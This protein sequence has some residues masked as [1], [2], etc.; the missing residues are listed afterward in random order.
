M[1]TATTSTPRKLLSALAIVTLFLVCLGSYVRVTGAG[2]SCPDWPLC[3]GQVVPKL[4]YGVAQEVLHRAIASVVVV[5]TLLLVVVL[6]RS[7]LRRL[8]AMSILLFLLVIVQAVFG[9]LTVLIRL[10]PI[11]VTTH[12]V[13]GTTFFQIAALLATDRSKEIVASEL[14]KQRLQRLTGLAVALLCFQIVIGGYM[15]ASGA[16]LACSDHFLCTSIILSGHPTSAQLVHFL[17]RLTGFAVLATMAALALRAIRTPG[18]KAGIRG[19]LGGLAIT[20]ALQIGVGLWNYVVG[21][22]TT[23]SVIHILLA[24]LLLFS[25]LSTHFRLSGGTGMWKIRP[26][27][28]R[29]DDRKSTEARRVI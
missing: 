26:E 29:N 3:Y 23:L 27:D 4:E 15:T 22:S 21:I 18:L 1:T 20:T 14:D 17:H 28:I 25:L 13:L 7:P 2:L 10:D 12:L 9:G 11:V 16:S 24:Q 6:R 19:H 5:L 8:R